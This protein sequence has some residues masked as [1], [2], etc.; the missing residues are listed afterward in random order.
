MRPSSALTR[1]QDALADTRE[2]PLRA[3]L[4]LLRTGI[5][6][7]RGDH[8]TALAVVVAGAEA[9]GDWPVRPSIREQFGAHEALLRA[10]LGER[11]QAVALLGSSQASLPGAVVLAQLQLGDGEHEA[12]RATLAPWREEMERERSP[13]C[14]QAWLLEALALDARRR[15]RRA[16]R[17]PSRR[18]STGPSRAACAGRCWRSGARCSRCCGASSGAAPRTRRSCGDI[19]GALERDGGP[20]AA[21]RRGDGRAAQPARAC[22]A[23]LPAD[24]DV[25]PGDRVRAVRLRQHGQDAPEGD[26]PQAR[27]AGPPRGRPPRAHDEPPGALVRQP[28]DFDQLEAERLDAIDHAVELGLVAYRARGARSRPARGRSPS[29]RSCRGARGSPGP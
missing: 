2:R 27:R 9:L 13:A 25:Q 10:E 17:P 11:A 26:L 4:S 29:P 15:P 6:T 21:P 8:E 12:A 28:P 20:R 24:D 16:R 19:V 5:L 7:A 22:G 1:A 18:R 14:V 23:P 3:V